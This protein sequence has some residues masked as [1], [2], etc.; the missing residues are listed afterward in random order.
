MVFAKART[1][2]TACAMAGIQTVWLV[3]EKCGIKQVKKISL[4]HTFI[5]SPGLIC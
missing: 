3:E 5:L 2:I 1:I 4:S